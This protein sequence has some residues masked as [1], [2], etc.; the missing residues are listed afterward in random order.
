ML[1][2]LNDMIESF[3]DKINFS[4]KQSASMPGYI[5]RE[6]IERDEAY[7]QGSKDALVELRKRIERRN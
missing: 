5:R 1:E 3:I 2:L 4:R 6:E 7:F